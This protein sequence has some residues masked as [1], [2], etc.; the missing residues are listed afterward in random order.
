M[1]VVDKYERL[2]HLLPLSRFHPVAMNHARLSMEKGERWLIALSGGADSVALLTLLW[3]HFPLQRSRMI[4]AHFN[5]RLRGEESD[6][7]EL[8]CQ[9]LCDQLGILLVRETWRDLP[10]TLSEE[11]ARNARYSFFNA[12][13]EKEQVTVLLT[14]HQKNDIAET[15]LMRL[16]RGASSA[17][18]AAPRPVR[19]WTNGRWILRPLLSLSRAEIEKALCGQEI[20][21]REDSTN[22]TGHYF[23]NRIRLDVVPAWL[24]ASEDAALDGAALTRERLEEEDAALEAWLDQLGFEKTATELNLALLVGQPRAL[25]RRALHRWTHSDTLSRLAFDD[26]LTLCQAG[27]GRRSVGE[28]FAVI[29]RY[30]LRWERGENQAGVNQAWL[31]TRWSPFS[32]LA[33]PSGGILRRR[34]VEVNEE[35]WERFR[36]GAVD[37]SVEAVV[38]FSSDDFVVRSWMPGDRYR[39]LGSPGTAKVQ[40]LFVN[41]KVPFER[42]HHLPVVCAADGTI[43]WIPGFPPAE[44]SKVADDSVT[45]VQL[46]YTAGTITIHDYSHYQ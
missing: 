19:P 3:T 16:S 26:L 34:L 44:C 7:D 31:P 41:R 5:H 6:A 22:A 21:W 36:Q 24:R 30:W 33:L 39:P 8:F 46:T 27:H 2:A 4:A 37:I 9:Q 12:T 15:Q 11:A 28:G 17:G 1:D 20:S 18:L 14:G 35:L 13:A 43:L 10:M 23:R 42:R 29:E 40:D 38:L 25:W 32:L 45:A